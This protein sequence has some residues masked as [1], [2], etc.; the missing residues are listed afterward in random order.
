MALAR[1][2]PLALLVFAALA[3]PS[4]AGTGTTAE[5]SA[6]AKQGVKAQVKRGTLTI[7]GNRRANSV[8]LRLKRRKRGTLEVDVA[9][10]KKVDFRFKLRAFKRIVVRGA[11][12]GD[13]LAIS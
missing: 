12:G 8:T 4:Q 6:R 11:G 1:W 2:S 7:T 10:S 5:S 13:T 3:V 9:G